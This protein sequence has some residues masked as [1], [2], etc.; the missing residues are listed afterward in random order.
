M[1]SSLSEKMDLPEWGRLE[2][3]VQKKIPVER[4]VIPI[5]SMAT[6]E[7]DESYISP[8]EESRPPRD[9]QDLV[10]E[11]PLEEILSTYVVTENLLV[12]A[13]FE[14]FGLTEELKAFGL[15]R[16]RVYEEGVLRK[17]MERNQGEEFERARKETR[18]TFELYKASQAWIDQNL[19]KSGKSKTKALEPV[20]SP[21]FVTAS[22]M[23]G[24]VFFEQ[25]EATEDQ[26]LESAEDPE[27]EVVP[28]A[29]R[30]GFDLF[31][32]SAASREVPLIF[33]KGGSGIQL[34]TKAYLGDLP[35]SIQKIQPPESVLSQSH[36]MILVVWTGRGNYRESYAIVDIDLDTR[37]ARFSVKSPLKEVPQIKAHIAAQTPIL[38]ENV[39]EEG[40]LSKMFLYGLTLQYSLWMD[41][42]TNDPRAAELIYMNESSSPYSG[43]RRIEFHLTRPGFVDHKASRYFS[44]IFHEKSQVESEVVPVID[45]QKGER[46]SIY[47]PAKTPYL[48]VWIN[49][50]YDRDT[51]RRSMRMLQ[52]LLSIYL[53][54]ESELLKVYAGYGV[55]LTPSK[56]QTFKTR[57]TAEGVK[58]VE[59]NLKRGAPHIF[60]TGYSRDICQKSEKP[61]IMPAHL[62]DEW[63]KTTG[64]EAEPFPPTNPEFYVGCPTAAHSYVS[65]KDNTL[66]NND[67]YPYLPCCTA[68]DR[69]V[70]GVQSAFNEYYRNMPR[71][72]VAVDTKNILKSRRFLQPGQKG[73][74]PEML[75]SLLEAYNAHTKDKRGEFLR[76]GVE[77]ENSA[78]HAVFQAM[79]LEEYVR[80]S[81]K[82]AFV[83]QELSKPF[84]TEFLAQ[85]LYDQSTEDIAAM[86]QNQFETFT[87]YR[88]LE[89]W[90]VQVVVFQ[91]EEW[92]D[93]EIEVPR[94]LFFHARRAS[95]YPVVLLLKH[96]GGQKDGPW[97]YEFIQQGKKGL[98]NAKQVMRLF[99]DAVQTF[100]LSYDDGLVLRAPM[101]EFD[102]QRFFP[103]TTHQYID[104]AGKCRGVVVKAGEF[105]VSIFFPPIQPLDLPVTVH[106][107]IVP[108]TWVLKM[109]SD[110]PTFLG[111]ENEKVSGIWFS[112][113]DREEGVY[114]PVDPISLKKAKK[115]QG[116]PLGR[117]D[118][119][120]AYDQPIV[121]RLVNLE[122]M[123]DI[124]LQVLIWVFHI[125]YP[126]LVSKNA[127]SF[128]KYLKI[129]DFDWESDLQGVSTSLPDTDDF[130]EAMGYLE[131]VFPFVEEGAF[132]C[133]NREMRKRIEY[134]LQTYTERY[135]SEQDL[136]QSRLDEDEEKV[137]ETTRDQRMDRSILKSLYKNA[138]EF[139]K[140]PDNAVFTDLE[141]FKVWVLDNQTPRLQLLHT[142]SP[143][144]ANV[145]SPFL[146]QAPNDQTF[147]IQNVALGQ[148]G[149][150]VYVAREYQRTGV[151][152]GFNVPPAESAEEITEFGISPGGVL[153][154]LTEQQGPGILRFQEDVYAAILPIS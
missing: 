72:A 149:R 43:R 70:P 144:D 19:G 143:A 87:C 112:L 8:V 62:K 102:P 119:Y 136:L 18:R 65:M 120:L 151:N 133:T 145:K 99:N 17:D 73:Y 9:I 37:A 71:Q 125:R 49:H 1:E 15:A 129:K 11:M 53:R 147:L 114:V 59:D 13:Y 148:K 106:Q 3:A 154:R 110:R 36:H 135:L 89:R 10:R 4:V 64:H 86:V 16:D 56:L 28:V 130:E 85:E 33:Y 81:D 44:F 31:L 80:A 69:R 122:R 111:M 75:V 51:L 77:I 93:V 126:H 34:H 29:P 96:K 47:V 78:V 7:G 2:F 97:R 23:I 20:T 82:A 45:Y 128:R 132:L 140:R 153:V 105:K 22:Q 137:R 83:R 107:Y 55:K 35:I 5:L 74:L 141:Q 101:M 21:I 76:I 68:T 14:V 103:R 41:M 139:L 92:D 63:E 115:L 46:R 58:T 12:D 42:I 84:R 66:E 95:N 90:G 54:R 152:L 116:I 121:S 40:M 117:G 100:E 30:N 79:E 39:R 27:V 131:E 146:Y 108:Y 67:K 91:T 118:P 24:E 104:T 150:A 88:W 134:F 32:E 60:I 113:Y 138:S 38:L 124:Y 98:W 142:L 61:V 94:H 48:K 26:S 123:R 25:I 57:A 50:T 127:R 109:F 52:N 6:G